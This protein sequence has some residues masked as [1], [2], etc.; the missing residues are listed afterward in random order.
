MNTDTYKWN[1]NW[2]TVLQ[3][4]IDDNQL[5]SS[6]EDKDL[7]KDWEEELREIR[8]QCRLMK[9]TGISMVAN[10]PEVKS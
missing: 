8:Y 6:K 5:R 10:V 9:S 1:S 3:I 7:M 4:L 2:A